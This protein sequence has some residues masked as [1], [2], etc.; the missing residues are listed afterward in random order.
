MPSACERP[1]A[2]R[3]RA[4]VATGAIAAPV[5]TAPPDPAENSPAAPSR[6]RLARGRVRVPSVASNQVSL[7][8]G[9]LHDHPRHHLVRI[10][11]F[12]LILGRSVVRSRF[13]SDSDFSHLAIEVQPL[14]GDRRARITYR[15]IR[16]AAPGSSGS[17][18]TALWTENP[19]CFHESSRAM[20]SSSITPALR[21][22]EG[23]FVPQQQLGRLRIHIGDGNPLAR[24]RPPAA[25]HDRE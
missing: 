23:H 5:A 8:V 2:R 9:N 11:P 21:S 24:L 15:T 1:C 4:L 3:S 10:E 25:A 22:S 19:L 12:D 16:S 20:R 18:L 17:T 6:L 14:L 7:R 13:C